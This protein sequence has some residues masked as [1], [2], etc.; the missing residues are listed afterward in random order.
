MP[1]LVCCRVAPGKLW[2]AGGAR[3]RVGDGGWMALRFGTS[4][5]RITAA[6]RL[7]VKK[8]RHLKKS[9]S[10]PNTVNCLA[11]GFYSEQL[12]YHRQIAAATGAP[13]SILWLTGAQC[14]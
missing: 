13:N 8:G 6:L 4:C 5:A 14:E 10:L 7:T 9:F 1:S 12:C 2:K 3:N 11:A